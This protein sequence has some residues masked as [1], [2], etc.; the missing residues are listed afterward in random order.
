M[1]FARQKCLYMRMSCSMLRSSLKMMGVHHFFLTLLFEPPQH[2]VCSKIKRQ[3]NCTCLSFYG[4]DEGI[5]TPGLCVANA[6][7][8]QLSHTPTT[9][10]RQ[11]S[12]TPK[13]ESILMTEYI[14]HHNFVLFKQTRSICLLSKIKSTASAVLFLL[15]DDD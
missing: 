2:L 7:L 15:V 13:K 4:G 10:F 6:S 11:L 1:H 12:H 14:L 8:Y 9:Y 3:A 5:R